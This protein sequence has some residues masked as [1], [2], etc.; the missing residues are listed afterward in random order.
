MV[1]ADTGFWLAL[2]NRRDAYHENAIHALDALGDARLIVTWPV[3]T[4][5][6]Y[7]LLDRLGPAA[8]ARFLAS[9]AAGAFEIAAPE[10]H[11]PDR[12]VPLM[13][14]HEALPMDLADAPLVL[15]AEW[16]GHGRILSVD[17][18]DFGASRWKNRHPFKKLLLKA[19]AS[20][21][22]PGLPGLPSTVISASSSPGVLQVGSCFTAVSRFLQGAGAVAADQ[23]GTGQ[24]VVTA[25]V[26]RVPFQSLPE[27]VFGFA[28]PA[29]SQIAAAQLVPAFSRGH[30]QIPRTWLRPLCGSMLRRTRR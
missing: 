8:Q 4:E 2:A 22:L 1:M 12:L 6:C 25:A 15:L 14:K 13:E 27:L 16:L 18:R 7:L 29:E 30:A 17:R 19:G 9:H 24:T 10:S 11:P 26:A 28:E 5:T 21:G 23:G 20:A 3:M